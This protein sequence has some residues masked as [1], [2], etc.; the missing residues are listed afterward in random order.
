MG[1]IWIQGGEDRELEKMEKRC[2][3]EAEALVGGQR[4]F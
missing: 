2:E 1:E 4:S 3:G